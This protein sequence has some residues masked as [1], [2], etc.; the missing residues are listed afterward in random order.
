MKDSTIRD[1]GRKSAPSSARRLQMSSSTRVFKRRRR[2]A[3][4]YFTL[5]ASTLCVDGCFSVER[6]RAAYFDK[7]WERF[8]AS[9]AMCG[10]RKS[11]APWISPALT[12]IWF[13]EAEFA[14]TMFN[15]NIKDQTR[16]PRSFGLPLRGDWS[17]LLV[18]VLGPN[19][20]TVSTLSANC[21]HVFHDCYHRFATSL[22]QKI[23]RMYSRN[24]GAK[25]SRKKASS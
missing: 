13:R 7:Y 10:M 17:H 23:P 22:P 16:S 2:N 6:R 11:G 8:D 20:P 18:S 9:Y 24:R 14:S 4:Q 15:N 5:K 1:C 21:K 3:L 12:T 19:V 25:A